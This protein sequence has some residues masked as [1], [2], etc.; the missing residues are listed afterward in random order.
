MML[1]KKQ[2]MP[3]QQQKSTKNGPEMC[4]LIGLSPILVIL[5]FDDGH[6]PDLKKKCRWFLKNLRQ[7]LSEIDTNNY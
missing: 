1:C 2:K 4:F 3:S 7:A 6:S 5:R